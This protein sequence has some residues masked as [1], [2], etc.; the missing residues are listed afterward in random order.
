MILIFL[1]LVEEDIFEPELPIPGIEP[2][3]SWV[4]SME[5]NSLNLALGNNFYHLL[6][7]KTN[8]LKILSL[9][10]RDF[11]EHYLLSSSLESISYNLTL[12]HTFWNDVKM[13]KVKGWKW[14]Y[15]NSNLVIGWIEG[16]RVEDSLLYGG[17]FR[18]YH[19]FPSLSVG[20]WMSHLDIPDY[21]VIFAL[22]YFR[23][24]L[25]MKKR[26]IGYIGD[27]GD[28]KIGRFKDRFPTVFF[29]LK[30][31]YPRYLE[32]Y[33]TNINLF[34][35]NVKAGRRDYYTQGIDTLKWIEG[36]CYFI[37]LEME[38]NLFGFSI[39]YQ[40]NGIVK[41]YGKAYLK[42]NVNWLDYELYITGFSDPIEYL[43]GGLSLKLSNKFSP[44]VAVRNLSYSSSN[45]LL[46]P[47]YFIGIHYVH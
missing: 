22:N 15:S 25:G 4:Y 5:K 44:F 3:V 34:N 29:P 2:N 37:T 47:V 16:I 40:N 1:I 30:R 12:E 13:T 45:D 43:T 23:V 11:S 9:K 28:V 14:L 24:E 39:S 31:S 18:C 26:C 33:G 7:V 46:S 38:Y 27:W 20:F 17:G 21:G 10:G 8:K 6:N 35:L 41:G 36:E 42:G 19:S 32:Y